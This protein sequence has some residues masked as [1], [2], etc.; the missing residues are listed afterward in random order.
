MKKVKTI[1]QKVTFKL[2][3]KEA[4]LAGVGSPNRS[5]DIKIKGKVCGRINA[6]NWRTKDSK[7]GITIMVDQDNAWKW[8]VFTARLSSMDLAKEWV[9]K[10][11]PAILQKYRLYFMD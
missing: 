2:D 10:N 7:Y 9:I 4:G 3:T 6:P 8:V 5:A 11:M 1:K